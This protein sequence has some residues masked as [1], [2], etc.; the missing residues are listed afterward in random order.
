M[1]VAVVAALAMLVPGIAGAHPSPR[2]HPDGAGHLHGTGAWGDLELVS[3]EDITDTPDLVADVA[4]SPDGNWAY[5]ANWGEPDCAAGE[6]GGQT[7]PDAGAWVVDIG[8][9]ADPKTVG[10][11]PSHQDSRPGE[12]MQVMTMST[13]HFNGQIL[14]MN[15]EQCGPQGKGGVSLWNVTNP[16]KPMKLSEN[17]GDRS[18]VRGDTNDIHSQYTWDAGDKAYVVMTDNAEFPDVDVMDITNPSRPRLIAEYDLN[19]FGVAQPEHGLVESFLHDMTVK[20]IDGHWIMLLSYWDGGYVQL[21]VD[22]PTNPVFLGDTDYEAIDPEL[23]ES[24]GAA[25]TPEGNGHEAEFTK[26]NRFFLA[27]DEDFA[28]FRTGGFRITSGAHAGAYPSVIVPGGAAPAI[29]PDLTMNGP[30]VY[31]GY[32][33]P[34]SDPIPSPS[35]VPDYLGMLDPGEDKIVVLQRGPSGDPS[36]SE[37]ACFPG[38]KAHQAKL[39]GWDAVLFVQRHGADAVENPPF[40]GSGAFVDLIVGV[41]TSHEAFHRIFDSAPFTAPW[42]YP[43]GPAIGAIGAEVEVGS[44]FDGWGYVQ[45]FDAATFAGLDTF[46]IPEAHDPAFALDFGDLS[47]HE[48]ATDVSSSSD[49]YLSYYGGGMRS[50]EIQCSNPADTSTCEIVET[51]GY[52]DPEGNDFWGVETFVRGGQTYVLGSD[53]DDGLW[54]FRTTD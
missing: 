16:R 14:S 50:I 33:C 24:T 36:A 8:N 9:L 11:I 3:V 27:T 39:A 54:I 31:G 23:F 21:D 37:G 38:E 44:V 13:K 48:V 43:D 52:L 46:A 29:L 15:N 6:T 45:L 32:G 51:G 2:Q 20:K 30:T 40:C 17:F 49:A 41:C 26:D 53:R 10:F 25:L 1:A 47:V 18:G 34:G 22:D 42:T 4:V 19:Q 28:P 12:G 5:L 7:S 35:Q